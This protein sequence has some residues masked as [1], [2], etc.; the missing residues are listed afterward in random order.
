MPIDLPKSIAIE[1]NINVTP[2]ISNTAMKIE[3][4][5]FMTLSGPT[6]DAIQKAVISHPEYNGVP[7]IVKVKDIKEAVSI[8][9][10]KAQKGDI[11]TLS[12]ACA[13]FDAFPNFE[14]R[15]KYFKELVNEL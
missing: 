3:K 4:V 2:A 11:V 5:K 13:S 15:G 6:A 14:A 12:P 7:E 10:K 8:I 1:T 9:H